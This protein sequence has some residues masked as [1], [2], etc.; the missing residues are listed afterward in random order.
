MGNWASRFHW[1]LRL[2][3][4]TNDSYGGRPGSK[5]GNQKE[6]RKKETGSTQYHFKSRQAV[7]TISRKQDISN[8]DQIL[9]ESFVNM[10]TCLE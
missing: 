9:R 1:L 10:T 7:L 6:I 5:K 2:L 4:R 3:K 8:D